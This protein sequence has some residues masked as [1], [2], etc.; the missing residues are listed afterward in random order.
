MNLINKNDRIFIA[1]HK[2]MV[3]SAIYR[4]LKK[5]GYKELLI[6]TRK[7]LNLLNT[8]AV[9]KWFKK[10]K[11][12]IV[13]L[14]AA[15]VGGIEANSR[16]SGDFILENLKIQTNIIENSWINKVKRFIF[17]GSSCIYPKF[18]PQ[19]IKEEYLLSGPLETTNEPY[20]IAKIAGIKLCTSLK[21]Q[22]GFDV[23]NLMPTNLYGPGDNYHETN[24]HVMPALI[25]KFYDA[26]QNKVSKVTCWGT[27]N[28]KREFLF[29][30]DL[31]EAS[32]FFLEKISSN[33]ELLFDKNSLFNGII[34]IGSGT[35]ISIKEL[36]NLISEEIGFQ[37]DILWDVSKPDGTPRKLLD[38]SK[39]NKLGWVAKTNLH[40]GI[41]KTIRDFISGIK[42]NTIRA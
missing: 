32:I 21:K 25:K 4:Q 34:N 20:A 10:N 13:I 26:T 19:P 3:G 2:G 33:N 9:E 8:D 7:E 24:S 16:Y 22:Y 17:L 41:K 5:N 31:A 15:K 29:V 12:D 1:G 14:A 18:S 35:D 30:E 36:A 39:A 42:E 11:P 23:I 37:G 40:D 28:P 6:A 27:G 38:V